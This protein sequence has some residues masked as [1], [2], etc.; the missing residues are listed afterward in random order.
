MRCGP[1]RTERRQTGRAPAKLSAR[2]GRAGSVG[3]AATIGASRSNWANVQIDIQAIAAALRDGG[4]NHALRRV[5]D[6]WS[7]SVL[8][9]MFTGSHRF[10]DIHQR[11]GIP[12]QTLSLRLKQ[13]IES[14]YVATRPYQTAPSIVIF[15]T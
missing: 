15:I 6:R 11:L 2:A 3:A 13:L 14:G 8:M 9:A 12:R 4:I 1:N 5:G 10:Q 7:Y